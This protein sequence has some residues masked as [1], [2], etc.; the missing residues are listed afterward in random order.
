MNN[1]TCEQCENE[2]LRGYINLDSFDI[3]KKE[4]ERSLEV[5]DQ[6][7]DRLRESLIIN[8]HLRLLLNNK[9]IEHDF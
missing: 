1:T 5:L 8:S 4:L 2:R 6:T 3:T 9:G 7:F